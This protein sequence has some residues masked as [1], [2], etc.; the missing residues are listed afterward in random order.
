MN[1]KYNKKYFRLGILGVDILDK[2]KPA[3]RRGRKATGP[4]E[5]SRVAEAKGN[6]DMQGHGNAVFLIPIGW[7]R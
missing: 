4:T 7:K 1:R 3:G 6:F 2:G 5:D